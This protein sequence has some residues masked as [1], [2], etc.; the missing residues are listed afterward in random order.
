MA[1]G[2]WYDGRGRI[3]VDWISAV[4]HQMIAAA[5]AS[6]QQMFETGKPDYAAPVLGL[7]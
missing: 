4:V 7:N 2:V 1:L 6:K 3:P 5:N